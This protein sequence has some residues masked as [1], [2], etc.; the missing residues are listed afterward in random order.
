MPKAEPLTIRLW[1]YVR[2]TDGCWLWIGS[3][4]PTGYG[5]IKE[6]RS[7]RHL[8]AHRVSWE[9]HFGPIPEGLFVLHHCDNPCCVRPDHL[10]V[11]TNRDNSLD[12]V[13]KGRNKGCTKQSWRG[14]KSPNSKLTWEAAKDIRSGTETL[15]ALAEKYG[16]LKGA[17]WKVRAGYTWNETDRPNG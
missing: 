15:T 3:G 2:K 5:T 10:F 8:Y 11:G 12:C 4:L 1:R 13:A 7:R 6:D 16:V 9:F 14:E 17:I